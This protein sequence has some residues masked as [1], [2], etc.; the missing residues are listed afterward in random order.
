MLRKEKRE[1]T[2]QQSLRAVICMKENRGHA[3]E[4]IADIKVAKPS[5]SKRCGKR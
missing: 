3:K 5:T 1:K 4:R 2:S